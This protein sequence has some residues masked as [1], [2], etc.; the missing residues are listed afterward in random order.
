MG[1]R[2]EF[3]GERQFWKNSRPETLK[4]KTVITQ[5]HAI[6]F[7][8]LPST[9]NVSKD[10]EED[11]EGELNNKNAKEKRK[12]KL[13]SKSQQRNTDRKHNIF[14]SVIYSFFLFLEKTSTFFLYKLNI[15]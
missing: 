12:K 14:C 1:L 6:H 4:W 13:K 15:L 10:K 2:I 11:D 5:C 9:R 8:F 7:W 3:R